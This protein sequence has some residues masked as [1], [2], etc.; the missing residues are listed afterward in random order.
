MPYSK[1]LKNYLHSAWDIPLWLIA[2]AEKIEE[3]TS[4]IRTK[5][6]ETARINHL[7]VLKAFQEEG[8]TEYHLQGTT[9]YG[10]NDVGRETLDAIFARIFGS[11][12]AL[13]RMQFVS[14]THALAAALYGNLKSGD[15]LVSA[16]GTPYDT[17]QKIIG[18]SEKSISGSL[19]ERGIT[20][21]EVPLT[22]AGKPDLIRLSQA[23]TPRTRMVMIQRSSGY[24]WRPALTIEEIKNIIETVK[25]INP[26][27]I[28]L[29]DNCYGE[30][31][32]TEEPGVAGADL[33]AGSLIKN[34]GGG[35]APTGGYLVGRRDLIQG[36]ARRLTAPGLETA[37]GATL[38][39]NRLFYQ[40]LFLAPHMVGEALK[41]AVFC[42]RLLESLGWEVKPTFAEKRGDII[43]A[44]KLGT[45]EAVVK[46]CQAIQQY[47]PVDSKI[48]PVPA[49]LPGYAHEVIMA[50]GTFIQ[51]ASLE[52]TA[53]APMRPPYVVYLQGGL[54][55]SHPYLA[56]L[57]AAQLIENL[58]KGE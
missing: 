58:K 25:R 52:L 2:I 10:Y 8:V 9:G 37:M 22:P 34:P 19:R 51:G 29:V 14:G 21:R 1:T 53:D 17:L 41:G 48:K 36:A 7:R 11:E 12:A 39:I 47:S 33:T 40:G 46:F 24:S 43:Q 6:E 3:E 13:V 45:P 44:I 23:L 31:V 57:K 18:S 20:Y 54:G 15:E 49:L 27:I 55:M 38:G 28:C 35:L 4:E 32:E 30:F 42:A 50:A 5:I 16:T 26:H 56:I